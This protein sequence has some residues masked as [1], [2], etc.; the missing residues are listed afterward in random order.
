[1]V[2]PC[3]KQLGGS[4]NLSKRAVMAAG[5]YVLP[6]LQLRSPSINVPPH[7][8]ARTSSLSFRRWTRRTRSK[9]PT[10]GCIIRWRAR[11]FVQ[12]RGMF[13]SFRTSV[14]A[15]AITTAPSVCPTHRRI[16]SSSLGPGINHHNAICALN[17]DIAL[18]CIYMS[19]RWS[20][21]ERKKREPATQWPRLL[22]PP[23][24]Q[25]L[26]SPACS[27]SDELVRLLLL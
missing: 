18:R 1:M 7:L 14:S 10:T 22:A 17:G 3:T 20:K 19:G 5:R 15:L 11:N 25:G 23:A 4:S 2:S 21:L 8:S 9:Q 12:I 13:D 16:S 24:S 27:L 6:S 26:S